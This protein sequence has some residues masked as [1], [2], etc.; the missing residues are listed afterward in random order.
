MGVK[1][2][3]FSVGFGRV[4]WSRRLGRDQTE[5]ALAAIPLVAATNNAALR[6][7]AFNVLWQLDRAKPGVADKVLAGSPLT[8][9][10]FQSLRDSGDFAAGTA[11]AAIARMDALGP[12]FAHV[13]KTPFNEIV[14][15]KA[16]KGQSADQRHVACSE[17]GEGSWTSTAG[18]WRP[19]GAIERPRPEEPESG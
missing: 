5:W 18:A 13:L 16:A 10:Y 14:G 12:A 8:S 11:P 4:L 6:Q 3:R 19:G 1:I 2:L 15:V 7:T 17:G 9:A